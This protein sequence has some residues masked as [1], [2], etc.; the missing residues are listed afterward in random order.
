[1]E[2]FVTLNTPFDVLRMARIDGRFR[3]DRFQN[4]D[5]NFQ[6]ETSN[7]NLP[8]LGLTS[9]I[10]RTRGS[11]EVSV[12]LHL[13]LRN[14]QQIQLLANTHYVKDFSSADYRITL[15][16]PPK[17]Y[18]ISGQY[19]INEPRVSGTVEM[20]Y[21][22]LK[23]IASG[24]LERTPES[25]DISVS[26][27]TPRSE[28]YNVGGTYGKSGNKHLVAAFYISPSNSKYDVNT[29]LSFNDYKNFEATLQLETPFSDYRNIEASINQHYNTN[30]LSTTVDYLKNGR[31]GH[32]K[33]FNHNRRNSVNGYIQL[34]CPFHRLRDVKISYNHVK[35]SRDQEC[36]LELDLNRVK[37]FK[38]ELMQFSDKSS[39]V[40]LDAP[41]LPLTM[42][43]D[44]KKLSYGREIN[45]KS[46]YQSRIVGFRTSFQKEPRQIL[47]DASFAWDEK[48]D[49]RISYDFKLGETGTGKELWGKLDTPLRSFMLKGNFTKASKASSGGIDFYWDASRNL[50]K[51]AA[52]GVEVTD[53]SNGNEASMRTKISLEH[54]KLSRVSLF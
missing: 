11:E 27:T 23:W 44:S 52:V 28:R 26:F 37:Q 53:M 3:N 29:S 36:S 32:L 2:A 47:H 39:H 7:I 46:E 19:G 8:T 34:T 50:E 10:S 12:M 42:T 17:R 20:E 45:F 16:I 9:K 31:R 6:L 30:Y 51:H 21:N 5:C 49:K 40:I 1:M 24:R 25:N 4:I 54:P 18:S 15:T 14:Y 38:A 41:V 43:A 13:P 22:N 33:V 48:A 35:K